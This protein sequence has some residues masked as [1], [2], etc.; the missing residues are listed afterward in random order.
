MLDAIVDRYTTKHANHPAHVRRLLDARQMLPHQQLALDYVLRTERSCMLYWCSGS[1][2]SAF[3]TMLCKG[4]RPIL[5]ASSPK[6]A[7]NKKLLIVTA[8]TGKTQLAATCAAAAGLPTSDPCVRVLSHRML[9]SVCVDCGD[10][11]NIIC[12]IS[13]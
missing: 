3:V 2:K 11:V 13:T 9:G 4:L 10:I 6:A 12:T 1:G 7:T 8:R 5:S